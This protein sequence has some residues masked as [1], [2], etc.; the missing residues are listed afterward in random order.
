VSHAWNKIVAFD[1]DQTTPH[2]THISHKHIYLYIFRICKF[3]PD[4]WIVS[5]NV[6]VSRLRNHSRMFNC[7]KFKT[8]LLFTIWLA[9]ATRLALSRDVPYR[10]KN[11]SLLTVEKTATDNGLRNLPV[12]TVPKTH[13][14]GIKYKREEE[15]IIQN[16]KWA[17]IYINIFRDATNSNLFCA[18]TAGKK[19]NRGV[20]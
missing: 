6:C 5:S 3:H 12:L 7:S 15:N 1:I 16:N 8:S 18:C 20:R 10:L 9:F 11:I 2:H 14:V 4:C 17:V 19:N 13:Y